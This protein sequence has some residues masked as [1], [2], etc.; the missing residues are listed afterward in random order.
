MRAEHHGSIPQTPAPAGASEFAELVGALGN[1]AQNPG[2]NPAPGEGPAAADDGSAESALRRQRAVAEQHEREVLERRVNRLRSELAEAR[3]RN[4]EAA[5]ELTDTQ[6]RLVERAQAAVDLRNTE[7]QLRAAESEVEDLR[8]CLELIGAALHVLSDDDTRPIRRQ[9]VR[10]VANA[11]VLHAA[12]VE[13]LVS[14]L[15]RA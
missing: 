1:L 13:S 5:R 4:E 14:E 15:R 6:F 8:R 2:Q 11:T 12:E 9:E 7:R 10:R 3:A